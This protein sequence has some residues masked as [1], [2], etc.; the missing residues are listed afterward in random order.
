MGIGIIGKKLKMTQI[1]KEDG[2]V[3]P[4]TLV[5]YKEG[6][7]VD[8]KIPEKDKAIEKLRDEIILA[9]N[10]IHVMYYRPHNWTPALRVE[11]GSTVAAN[12]S[13]IAILLQGIKY[14]SKTPGLMEP[15]P[16]YIADRMVKHLGSAISAF[17]QAA[18][19]RMMELH[20]GEI[21]DIYFSMHG[22]RTKRGR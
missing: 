4:V 21:E 6:Y 9:I 8:L 7:V 12:N 18:T 10:G 2:E 17:R 22:Y 19:M 13:R 15:Y 14:Q 1:F 5:E 20:Q 11:V 3:V 16:L